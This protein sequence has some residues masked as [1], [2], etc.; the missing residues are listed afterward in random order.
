M[1]LKITVED[2]KEIIVEHQILLDS[3]ISTDTP[4]DIKKYIIDAYSDIIMSLLNIRV[5]NEVRDCK[6]LNTIINKDHDMVITHKADLFIVKI[7]I[8]VRAVLELKGIKIDVEQLITDL[9]VVINTIGREGVMGIYAPMDVN[10]FNIFRKHVFSI[11]NATLSKNEM[12]AYIKSLKMLINWSVDNPKQ[13][14][15]AIN[16]TTL[17]VS[18]K[19]LYCRESPEY[20]SNVKRLLLDV[21]KTDYNDAILSVATKLLIYRNYWMV[22]PDD[23][24]VL[25]LRRKL[26]RYTDRLLTPIN[27][28]KLK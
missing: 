19:E 2:I 12:D 13:F 27:D 16:K 5:N 28:I 20:I 17:S 6:I 11:T 10:T 15:L 9:S 4:S 1:S 24:M 3:L 25:K 23:V 18:R 26:G 8:L 21:V 7:S 14:R 22:I